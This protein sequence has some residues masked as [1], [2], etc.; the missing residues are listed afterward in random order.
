MMT[1]EAVLIDRPARSGARTSIGYTSFE[2]SLGPVLVAATARGLCMVGFGDGDGL[3]CDLHRRFP[4]AACRRDDGALGELAD[5]VWRMIETPFDAPALPVDPDGTTFEKQVWAAL[6]AIPLGE[7]R[8]Y[9]ELAAAIGRPT[10]ARAVARAC[11]KNDIAVV[12]PCHRIVRASRALGGYR[13]GV[14]R[15]R[16]LITRERAGKRGERITA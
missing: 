5:G 12:V 16:A 15:K 14:D 8:S 9:A 6:Q 2:S 13:W 11:A 1:N 3:A 7:T 10:A 4:A